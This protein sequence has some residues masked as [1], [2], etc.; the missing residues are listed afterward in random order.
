RD[1]KVLI[2]AYDHGLEHG[3]A[4]LL[5]NRDSTDP[6]HVFDLGTH[7]DVTA[8]AVQKGLA[9]T[10]Y[11][12]YSDDIPLLVKLNGKSSLTT[13]E[14]YSALNCSVERA[15]ELGA[16]AVG[17]TI[18]PGSGREADMFET[19][20]QVQEN[21]RDYGLPVV[22]WAYPRGGT[23]EDDTAAEVVQYAARIS[24]ELGADIAK[25]K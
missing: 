5:A 17:Y 8:I 25:V 14:P 18:Y 13:A 7:D 21:A 1:G 20:R 10:Y 4:D 22:V 12:E 19:F 24:L 23:V 11:R 2:L 15:A 6:R 3:P 16:D 9:E